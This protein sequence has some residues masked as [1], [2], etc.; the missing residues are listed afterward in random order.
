MHRIYHLWPN[1]YIAFDL[2]NGTREYKDR[3]SNIQ[4]IAFVNYI[5]GHIFKLAFSRKKLGLPPENFNTNA[6]EILL[7]MYANPVNNK[8]KVEGSGRFESTMTA[9]DQDA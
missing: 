5:R 1:N 6:R 4:R 9:Q 3:Y 8:R 7:Q 2:L